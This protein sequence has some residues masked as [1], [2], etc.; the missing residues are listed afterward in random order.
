MELTFRFGLEFNPFLKNSKGILFGGSEYT[1]ASFQLDYLAR[2]Q[3]FW[4]PHRYSWTR[5]DFVSTFLVVPPQ[6]FLVQGG[7]Y[8][9]LHSHGE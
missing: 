7:L 8:Q 3:R 9:P 1:E 6:S 4:S 5:Q 2:T